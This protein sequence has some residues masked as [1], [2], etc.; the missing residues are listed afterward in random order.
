MKR[1]MHKH[2]QS[3]GKFGWG[4]GQGDTDSGAVT[5]STDDP[6]TVSAEAVESSDSTY[7]DAAIA[8]LL[9]MIEEEK[10]A[11]DVY[12]AFYDLYGIKVFD[13]IAAS[14]DRHFDALIAQAEALGIDTDAFVF[15]EAGEF[16]N[17]E[18]QALYDSLIAEGS[19]SLT[20]ALEV[21]VA[22]EERDM[23]DIAAAIDAVEG[24]VLADIYQNL[25][26][27]SVAHLA[28]FEGLLA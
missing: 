10:L 20:D 6:V 26:D 8:E 19:V 15:A 11:G 2:G 5:V 24:T 17:D 23:V 18:L 22:I 9:F 3:G 21:G 4:T 16:E 12:E 28:A 25:L 27:G 7:S 13:N 14:E 1:A